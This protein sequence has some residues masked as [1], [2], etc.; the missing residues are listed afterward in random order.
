MHLESILLA[1]LSAV[2]GALCFLFRL[3]WARSEKCEEDRVKIRIDLEQL[4]LEKGLAQ[5]TL[6][7]Y[8]RCPADECPF[9]DD[10]DDAACARPTQD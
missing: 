2:T 10:A 5:G 1:G 7:S 4:K 3:L 8:Q 9:R 6:L